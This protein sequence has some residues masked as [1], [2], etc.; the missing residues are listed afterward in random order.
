MFKFLTLITSGKNDSLMADRLIV[1]GCSPANLLGL[2]D[3]IPTVFLR[4]DLGL[5]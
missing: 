1:K 4:N 3:Q 2:G 5:F